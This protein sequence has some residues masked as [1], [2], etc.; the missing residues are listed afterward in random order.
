M[1]DTLSSPNMSGNKSR[2]PLNNLRISSRRFRSVELWAH[3]NVFTG[4]FIPPARAWSIKSPPAHRLP[5]PADKFTLEVA[6]VVAEWPFFKVDPPLLFDFFR[7]VLALVEVQGSLLDEGGGTGIL[8]VFRED[9][10]G[11]FVLILNFELDVF[12]VAF[13]LRDEAEL[14]ESA[15][16]AD[17]AAAAALAVVPFG[18]KIDAPDDRTIVSGIG[19]FTTDSSNG[20]ES[21]RTSSIVSSNAESKNEASNSDDRMCDGDPNK[22]EKSPSGSSLKYSGDS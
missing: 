16:A 17:R 22:D 7:K 13:D 4:G 8:R 20:K 18:S 3:R 9:G 1:L 10:N 21:S 2:S 12:D 19:S 6:E 11:I 15:A 5:D 14:L